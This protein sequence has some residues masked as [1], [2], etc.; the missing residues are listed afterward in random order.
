MWIVKVRS[1]DIWHFLE[2]CWIFFP[3]RLRGIFKFDQVTY[4]AKKTLPSFL[5]LS[6]SWKYLAVIYNASTQAITWKFVT[7][8]NN[9][10]LTRICPTH[11]TNFYRWKECSVNLLTIVFDSTAQNTDARKLPRNFV[12]EIIFVTI[13]VPNTCPMHMQL[14]TQKIYFHLRITTRLSFAIKVFLTFLDVT[15][16]SYYCILLSNN[17]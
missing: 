15:I 9:A 7:I 14:F 6:N 16:T 3:D 8:M 1:C 4:E 12:L 11:I 10:R 17:C 5:T 13:L 2:N